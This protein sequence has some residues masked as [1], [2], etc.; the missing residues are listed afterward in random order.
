MSPTLKPATESA[1]V[2]EAR[3]SEFLEKRRSFLSKPHG[4]INTFVNTKLEKFFYMISL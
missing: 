2:S 4:R 1:V 3:E